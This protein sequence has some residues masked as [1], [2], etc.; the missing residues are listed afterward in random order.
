VLMQWYSDGQMDDLSPYVWCIF[1]NRCCSVVLGVLILLILSN[2]HK[3][4]STKCHIFHSQHLHNI[5][6]SYTLFHRHETLFLG[7]GNNFDIHIQHIT[8]SLDIT[9][10]CN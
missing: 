6:Q 7:N 3:F 8:N 5:S 2:Y 1:W 9:H 4:F 10:P